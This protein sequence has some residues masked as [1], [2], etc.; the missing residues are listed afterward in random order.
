ML[1]WEV[2][3][4]VLELRNVDEPTA[5]S[6]DEIVLSPQ[7]MGICGSDRPKL[8][9]PRD[10][11]L[12]DT[13]RPGHEIVGTD[14]IGR[15][16]CVDPLLPCNKCKF[17][18]NE[19]SHCCQR[20]RRIGWDL[21]GGF[22]DLLVVPTSNAHLLPV[23]L[24]PLYA[25]L[26]DPMAVAVH[27]LQYCHSPSPGTLAVIGTGT[28]G[29]LSA[30]YASE[31]GYDVTLIYRDEHIPS[32]EFRDTFGFRFISYSKCLKYQQFNFVIDAA[33][34]YTA[35]P[36]KFA[37]RLVQDGGTIVVQ[38]AY[39]PSVQLDYPLRDIFRRSIHL[40]GSFSYG[41]AGKPTEFQVALDFLTRNAGIAK[42]LVQEV[43]GLSDLRDVIDRRQAGPQRQVLTARI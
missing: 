15:W 35:E 1:A 34:G 31:L 5:N 30:A 4:G 11:M 43:G 19:M 18:L 25:V 8:L 38:N 37:L 13:W 42:A 26:V 12:L 9:R 6:N 3:A 22:A 29:V 2:Q 7:Y 32:I 14:T 24:E 10:F 20:L 17:C 40:V 36:L 28:V 23:G 21:P 16:Y 39:H 27:G 33:S 41:N